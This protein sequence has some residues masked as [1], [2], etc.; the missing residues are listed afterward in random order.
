[1]RRKH[2]VKKITHIRS[3]I[4]F[5][6]CRALLVLA[7]VGSP[8]TNNIL[9]AQ[10][11]PLEQFDAHTLARAIFPTDQ[12][13]TIVS[14]EVVRPAVGGQSVRSVVLFSQPV[15]VGQ[16]VCNRQTYSVRL[17]LDRD[18]PTSWITRWNEL[19]VS[20]ECNAKPA[21]E[22]AQL[23]PMDANVQDAAR[24]LASFKSIAHSPPPKLDLV[25]VDETMTAECARDARKTLAGLSFDNLFVVKRTGIDSWEFTLSIERTGGPVWTVAMSDASTNRPAIK[26]TLT[27]PPPF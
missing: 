9:Q 6:A 22:F 21:P 13:S 2:P 14:L 25:C 23:H 8:M 19:A 10:E 18:V 7:A 5:A 24:A 4:M 17:P 1:M 3:E 20:A 12:A 16:G 27:I 15:P 11:A 26:M